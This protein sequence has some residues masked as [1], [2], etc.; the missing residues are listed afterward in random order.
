MQKSFSHDAFKHYLTF[1]D[2][3]DIHAFYVEVVVR[4]L[5]HV[6]PEQCRVERGAFYSMYIQRGESVMKFMNRMSVS[7][8]KL[9]RE[10]GQLRRSQRLFTEWSV[11]PCDVASWIKPKTNAGTNTLLR[12]GSTYGE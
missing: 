2:P 12:F 5:S 6:A 3:G 4:M 1:V 9:A 10:E 11:L 8:R 7:E